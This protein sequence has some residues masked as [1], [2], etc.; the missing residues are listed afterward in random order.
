MTQT[1]DGEVNKG[2]DVEAW[3]IGLRKF[4]QLHQYT[5]NMEAILAIYH[6]QGKSSI[7]GMHQAV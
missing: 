3:F 7:W 1:F 6:M 4:F 2:E 5:P